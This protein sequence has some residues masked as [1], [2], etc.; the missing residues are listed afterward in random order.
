MV[1]FSIKKSRIHWTSSK[2]TLSS[3]ANDEMVLAPTSSLP[4][5][6]KAEKTL[7]SPSL[8]R[9][10]KNFMSLFDCLMALAK[11]TSSEAW[12]SVMVPPNDRPM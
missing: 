1:S 6:L 10:Q 8:K 11:S 12:A 5:E 9:I 3:K 7:S 4:K 2:P